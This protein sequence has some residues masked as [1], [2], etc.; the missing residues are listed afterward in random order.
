[1]VFQIGVVPTRVDILTK[2][3]GVG[4]D[5][6]WAERIEVEI[7][8]LADTVLSRAHLLRNE[9][10]SGRPKDLIDADWLE[11]QGTPAEPR[12]PGDPRRTPEPHG[13]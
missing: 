3:D 7:D 12:N 11:T 2:I 9:R 1:M 5:E 10:A 8:G 6:A 13:G 4:F